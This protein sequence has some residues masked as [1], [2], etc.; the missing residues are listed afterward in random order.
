MGTLTALNTQENRVPS[1]STWPR[2]EETVI[3]EREWAED[4][5]ALKASD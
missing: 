4:N 1:P 2:A 5:V 3:G